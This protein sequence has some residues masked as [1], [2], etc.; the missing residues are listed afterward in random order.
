MHIV[1]T[2]MHIVTTVMHI[3]LARICRPRT[4]RLVSLGASLPRPGDFTASD[5]VFYPV[6]V[7]CL[8]RPRL[9]RPGCIPC[10]R[11]GLTA[12]GLVSLGASLLRPG[13]FTA[14]DRVFYPV[15][16]TGLLRPRL[17]LPGCVPCPRSGLTA[18]KI[19]AH[20]SVLLE[21]TA[22]DVCSTDRVT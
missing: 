3:V 18:S 2:V 14:S 16:V 21:F 6:R 4:S 20:A 5:R 10:P 9:V 13:D 19:R 15:R 7:T 17:V 8:L 22:S 12:S 11:S 1:T